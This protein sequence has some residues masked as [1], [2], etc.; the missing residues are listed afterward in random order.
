MYIMKN[1]YSLIVH[2]NILSM[3]MRLFLS[4]FIQIFHISTGFFF[5]SNSYQESYDSCVDP[6]ASGEKENVGKFERYLEIGRAHV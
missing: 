1:A 5:C 4:L 6:A 3:S 2:F